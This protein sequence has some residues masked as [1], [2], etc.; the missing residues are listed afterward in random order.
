MKILKSLVS[1]FLILSSAAC[2]NNAVDGPDPAVL[3]FR[4]DSL[5]EAEKKLV[6]ILDER[7]GGDDGVIPLPHDELTELVTKDTSTLSY[8]FELMQKKEYVEVYTSAD[9]NLRIYSW[10]TNMGGTMIDWGG[11]LQ[12]R[13]N[14][15]VHAET[16]SPYM[17]PEYGRDN[18]V[19]DGTEDIPAIRALHDIVM[20]DG[21]VC[22]VIENYF[23]YASNQAWHGLMGLRFCDGSLYRYPLFVTD[24]ETVSEIGFETSIADWYFRTDDGLGWDWVYAYDP[25]SRTFYEPVCGEYGHMTDQYR[26]YGFDGRHFRITE[27]EGGYWLHRSL[28][29]FKDLIQIFHTSAHCIRIDE[30]PDGSFRYASWQLPKEMSDEPDLII[31]NGRFDDERGVYIFTNEGYSYAVYL[32][33]NPDGY[34]GLK[35]SE[36]GRHLLDEPRV[37]RY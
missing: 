35:L 21:R 23:R 7:R 31:R 15:V 5:K 37:T 28:R 8:P 1:I 2:R 19:E 25:A 13:I 3:G 24:A 22:Y 10:N 16:Y 27:T 33:D 9:G 26:I 34:E 14:G 30:M 29:T 17:L 32:S 18:S 12:Y 36:N 4:Y 20:D 11:I 6:A